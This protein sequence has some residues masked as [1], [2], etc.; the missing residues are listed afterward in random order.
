MTKEGWKR[1]TIISIIVASLFWR[2]F[3]EKFNNIIN[4]RTLAENIYERQKKKEKNRQS[5]EKREERKR[6][7]EKEGIHDW[8]KWQYILWILQRETGGTGVHGDELGS[9]RTRQ[10]KKHGERG[11]CARLDCQKSGFEQIEGLESVEGFKRVRLE[12]GK[13]S[14]V[15]TLEGGS[16]FWKITATAKVARAKTCRW[17]TEAAENGVQGW[18]ESSH[19]HLLRTV[20]AWWVLFSKF[21]E[22]AFSYLRSENSIFVPRRMADGSCVIFVL[23][24]KSTRLAMNK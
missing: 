14:G 19:V 20:A 1:W 7:I 18:I 17:S 3:E 5:L 2:S 13:L 11:D 16:D 24:N 4:E 10:K 6:I 12:A 15:E 9:L 8:S 21:I 23:P 22:F